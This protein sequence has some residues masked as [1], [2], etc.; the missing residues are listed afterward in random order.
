[1]PMAYY[2]LF[3]EPLPVIAVI[4]TGPS[5]GSPGF[6]CM[7]SVVDRALAEAAIYAEAGVDGLLLKNLYDVPCVPESE[8]GPEVAAFMTRVAASVKHAFPDIPV[9]VQ[10]MCK[11]SRTSMAVALAAGCDFVRVDGWEQALEGVPAPGA[12]A[13][14]RYRHHI[15]A[16]HI[17][18]FADVDTSHVNALHPLERAEVLAWHRANALVVTGGRPGRVPD[19]GVL[20]AIRER[21]ELPVIVGSGM[22][23]ETLETYAPFA[24]GF[25]IGSAFK[26]HGV[27]NAPVCQTRA[28]DFMHLIKRVRKKCKVST[29]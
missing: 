20:Q 2:E 21:V 17:P 4:H 14:I 22:T 27:W 29:A 24:D 23:R 7:D 12:G 18:A 5:P 8:M 11:A 19:L 13:S 9:G 26:E 25:I 15:R 1:M 28:H 6:Y 3:S 10:V 16:E